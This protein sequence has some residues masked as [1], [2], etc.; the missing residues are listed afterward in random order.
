MKNMCLFAGVFVATHT[1]ARMVSPPSFGELPMSFRVMRGRATATAPVFSAR[2][3]LSA[4]SFVWGGGRS[5]PLTQR[6]WQVSPFAPV[7]FCPVLLWLCWVLSYGR[8]V[9]R[10]VSK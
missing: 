6:K 7:L 4:A 5:T 1:H 9:I 8:L 3:P 10:G 2:W